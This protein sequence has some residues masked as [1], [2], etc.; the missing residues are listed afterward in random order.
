MRMAI[1]GTG[2]LGTILG[3]YITKAGH[4]IDLIDTYKEHVDA[5]N[6]NGAHV[7][8]KVDFTVPVTAITPD[9][10]E[11][12]YDL[13]FYMAKQTYNETAFKQ[14]KPHVGDKSIIATC[15]NG[16]PEPALVKE[17]GENRVMGV[18]VG[19]GATFK[20]PGVS[21]LTSESAGRYFGLGRIDGTIT[22]EVEQV[23]KILELMAPVTVET[24]LLGIRWAKLLTNATMSGMSTV[25]AGTFG[26]VLDNEK[27]L[28]CAKYIANEC[29]KV[30]SAS[31]VKI[32]AV[33]ADFDPEKNLKFSTIEERDATTPRFHKR[34]GPHRA[35][36]ASMLQD[37]EKGRKCEID[38]I[39]GV[40]CQA[41]DDYNIDTPVND[42]VVDIVSRIEKG[43]LK[44]GYHADLIEIPEII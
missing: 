39:N 38:A 9:Q 27:A 44:L 43:K 11:G 21:E 29:L 1:M 12:V 18:P 36:K 41:G 34:W 22:P 42:Q 40:V 32:E 5:L 15:Q 20:E 26:D 25:I 37:L 4:K 28:L 17:F 13:V 33:P 10:M 19:W 7:V 23:K 35:L 2:S 3:A 6:K 30:A 31:G 14:L 24:N 16:L 8:G